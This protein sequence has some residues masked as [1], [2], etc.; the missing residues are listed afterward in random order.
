MP[1]DR[2]ETDKKHNRA[3]TKRE[4]LS[5]INE[6]KTNSG[7]ILIIE[8]NKRKTTV[9]I[10]TGVLDLLEEKHPNRSGVIE[11][12][13]IDMLEKE[14]GKEIHITKNKSNYDKT[15]KTEED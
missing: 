11:E 12:L 6:M 10:N 4:I 15:F 14:L 8:A 2:K 7:N 9:T 3:R 1:K 13:L 5:T